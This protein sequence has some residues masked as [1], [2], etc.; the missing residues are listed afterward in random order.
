MYILDH[1][2][3]GRV[4][5]CST[6]TDFAKRLKK[7]QYPQPDMARLQRFVEEGNAYSY[8]VGTLTAFK[9]PDGTKTAH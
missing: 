2:A 7:L 8:A 9:K 5:E 3:H 1:I 6:W 4:L